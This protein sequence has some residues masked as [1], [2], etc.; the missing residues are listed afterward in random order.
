MRQI[1]ATI[2]IICSFMVFSAT[3]NTGRFDN[4]RTNDPAKATIDV[5]DDVNFDTT[6]GIYLP[7][8]TSAQQPAPSKDG[9]IRYNTDTNS[10]ELFSLG[11]WGGIAGG[12]PT[13]TLQTA[14]NNSV[15]P[16]ITTTTALGSVDIQRGSAADTDKILRGL[17]GSGVEKFYVTGSGIVSGSSA[18]FGAISA[19]TALVTAGLTASSVNS[20]GVVSASSATFGAISAS[21]A[22][23]TAELTASSVNS[24]GVVS[25]SSAT[26]VT[27]LAATSGGTAQS[28]YTTGDILYASASNTLSK[29]ALGASDTVL[30]V[31]GSTAQWRTPKCFVIMRDQKTRGTNGGGSSTSFTARDLNTETHD[32]CNLSSISS[33]KFTPVAGTYIIEASAPAYLADWHQIRL[34]NATDSSIPTGCYGTSNFADKA[35]ES[36]NRAT[37]TCAFTANGTD[38]YEIQHIVANAQ[39]TNGFG[40]RDSTSI[41]DGEV[42]LTIRLDRQ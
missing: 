17:N 7:A 42:Y 37:L 3:E 39:A 24:L 20:L 34:R 27:P 36:Q 21:T 12:I 35:N 11:A 40:V 22:L 8:G 9:M 31:S 10:A 23:V 38:Q 6:G 15:T 28:T 1:I 2:L 5:L 32:N 26:L 4:L 33:N 41:G 25:A 14:Y 30:T 18:T 16:Q 13:G 29:L 19:G